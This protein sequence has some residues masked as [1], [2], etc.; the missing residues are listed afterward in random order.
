MN[1]ILDFCKSLQNPYGIKGIHLKDIDYLVGEKEF[2]S[3][4]CQ[5]ITK[6][7]DGLYFS[8]VR[9]GTLK[10]QELLDHGFEIIPDEILNMECK[11]EIVQKVF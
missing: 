2:K 8:W 4:K 6:L 9:R 10:E 3:D 11:R 5:W 7:D 1:T